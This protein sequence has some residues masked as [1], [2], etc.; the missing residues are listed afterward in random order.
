[1][2]TPQ[3][4][5]FAAALVFTLALIGLCAFIAR[6]FLKRLPAFSN[7]LKNN[8]SRLSVVEWRPLDGKHTLFLVKRDAV[9]H[10]ILLSPTTAPLLIEQ[11]IVDSPSLAPIES[12]PTP[13]LL[14]PGV[15]T[16]FPLGPAAHSP[17][18]KGKY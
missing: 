2:N 10:L 14:K 6:A 4:L 9:E 13:P 18:F 7:G 8:H 17:D 15:S 16:P 12:P 3:I 11:N 5:Q 1:M